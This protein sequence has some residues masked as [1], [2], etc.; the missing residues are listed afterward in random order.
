MDGINADSTS[1]FS[2][3]LSG[4]KSLLAEDFIL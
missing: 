4:V 3:L 1:E 2:I